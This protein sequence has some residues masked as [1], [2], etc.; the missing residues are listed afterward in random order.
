MEAHRLS[1]SAQPTK[2]D[3]KVTEVGQKLAGGRVSLADAAKV[4]GVLA[5]ADVAVPTIA[6][7]RTAAASVIAL[8]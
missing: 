7:R 8:A 5:D 3:V 1:P 2:A 6:N 4:P